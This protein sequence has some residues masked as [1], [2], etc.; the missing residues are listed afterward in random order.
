[1]KTMRVAPNFS[2]LWLA[3]PFLDRRHFDGLGG[4]LANKN[5]NYECWI[6]ELAS[7][8]IFYLLGGIL[9]IIYGVGR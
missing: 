4:K 1:M 9:Y 3:E 2:S 8:I 7:S 5:P 6:W